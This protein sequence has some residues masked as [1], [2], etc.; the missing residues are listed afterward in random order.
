MTPCTPACWTPVTCTRCGKHKAPRGRSVPFEAASSYC[1]D[2]CAGY[3]I[4]PVPHLWS[5]HDSTRHYTDPSG[6][7]AHVAG[8]GQCREGA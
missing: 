4:G 5:E 2:D 7:A 6:W 1:N 3:R 8:C